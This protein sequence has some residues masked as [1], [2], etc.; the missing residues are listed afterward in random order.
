MLDR[1]MKPV[2]IT[3]LYAALAVAATILVMHSGNAR[4]AV[5]G[6]GIVRGMSIAAK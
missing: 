6:D 3:M 4:A 5:E 1:L 2:T